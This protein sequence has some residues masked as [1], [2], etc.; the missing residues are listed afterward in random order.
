M[1]IF[2]LS[3][4]GSESRFVFKALLSVFVMD[5]FFLIWISYHPEK[6]MFCQMNSEEIYNIP[7]W[8]GAGQKEC[9]SSRNI[10]KWKRHWLLPGRPM[11]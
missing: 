10:H 3:I 1:L 4:K 11:S 5:P 6:R 9:R 7:N 2:L 8:K